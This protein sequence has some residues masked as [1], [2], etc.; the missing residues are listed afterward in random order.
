MKRS[1]NNYLGLFGVLALL[2]YTIAV[3]VVPMAYPGYDWASQAISDLSA[4]SAPSKDLWSQ[5][6]TIYEVGTIASITAVCIFI[7]AN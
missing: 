6:A 3:I 2:S 4:L 1:L 7:K 5:L